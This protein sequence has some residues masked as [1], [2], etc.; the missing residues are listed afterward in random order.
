VWEHDCNYR[1]RPHLSTD[2]A[3]MV[4]PQTVEGWVEWVVEAEAVAV[5]R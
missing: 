3:Q 4:E 5:A 1:P 2:A